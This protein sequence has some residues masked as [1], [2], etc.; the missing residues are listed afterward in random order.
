MR[1]GLSIAQG[2]PLSFVIYKY[3]EKK[4]VEKKLDSSKYCP[5]TG[6]EAEGFSLLEYSV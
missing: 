4:I 5:L 2:K 1:H 3:Y 6:E